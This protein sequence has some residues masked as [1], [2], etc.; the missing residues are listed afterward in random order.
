MK[1]AKTEAQKHQKAAEPA[2]RPGVMHGIVSNEHDA[3]MIVYEHLKNRIRFSHGVIYFR[4]E[5]I[6]ENDEDR[7][8]SCLMVEIQGSDIRLQGPEKSKP[9]AQNRNIASKIMQTLLDY[10]KAQ[11][12]DP[13]FYSKLHSTTKG[14]LA[15]LDGVLDIP[16]KHFYTWEEVEHQ[17][18]EK[19]PFPEYFTTRLIKRN[20]GEHFARRETDEDAIK[21]RKHLEELVFDPLFSTQKSDGMCFLA[22]A[23]AGHVSDKQMGV[24]VGNRNGSKGVLDKVV[25]NSLKA[26]HG[27]LETMNLLKLE[28]KHATEVEKLNQWLAVL[29]FTR[30]VF[31]NE[32]PGA[33]TGKQGKDKPKADGDKKKGKI[34]SGGDL[35][36]YKLNYTKRAA[37]MKVGGR[38][39]VLCND[40]VEVEP[41]DAMESI[42]MFSGTTQFKPKAY[43]ENL[44]TKSNLKIEQA[45]LM[46]EGA[47]DETGVDCVFPAETVQIH[48]SQIH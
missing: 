30:I 12:A 8:K 43:I 39:M 4:Q 18:E 33:G 3:V 20:Y 22:R 28:Q 40:M 11:G 10:V 21:A 24:Y 32:W 35:I 26:Y 17:D 1:K 2:P 25:E 16:N 44:K 42:V 48:V 34:A 38:L 29:E 9:F 41:R 45:K 37:K 27:T 15:F 23:V 14:K 31:G 47:E 36:D 19:R 13:T 7:M 46:M 6:W 5:H